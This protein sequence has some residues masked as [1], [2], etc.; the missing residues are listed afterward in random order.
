MKIIAFGERR[1]KNQHR[2]NLAV[3]L[4]PIMTGVLVWVMIKHR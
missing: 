4:P 3:C 2:E 1:A